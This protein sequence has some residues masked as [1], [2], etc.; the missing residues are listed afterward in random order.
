[1]MPTFG[2]NTDRTHLRLD[3]MPTLGPTMGLTLGPTLGP[4]LRPI[5]G[6]TVEPIMEPTIV[7]HLRVHNGTELRAHHRA[8]Q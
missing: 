6:S 7:A 4:N 5:I 1:M 3:I 2:A 8:Y